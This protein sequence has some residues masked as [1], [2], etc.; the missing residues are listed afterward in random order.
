M[1]LA[2]LHKYGIITT[3]PFSKYASPIFAQRKPNGRLRLLVNLRKINNLITEDYVNNNHP[4][5]TL[6][7]AAQHMAGK[8]LFCK[9]DCSQAYHCLQMA[10]YQSIQMLAFNFASRTFAYRRLAQGLSRSLSAFSSFMRE[11]LDRAIKTDQSAQYVDDIG[12]AA[13]DTKQLCT[14]I[15]T[16]FEC[17]RDAGLKLSMSK[18]H[19]GVKRVDFLG[20]TITPDGVAPQADKVKDFLSKLRFPKSKKALQRY[21]VFLNYYRN[22]IPRLSERLS[23]FF[24]LLKETSKF[25]V[26]T[27]LVEDFTNLNKLLE[28]SCQLALK[29]P[30]KNKQLIVMSDASFTAAGYAIMIVDDPNQKLQS[31]RKTYAPIASDSK[32]FNPTQTKMSIYAKEFLSICFA[33]VEFGHLM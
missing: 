22:Y 8:K 21:I 25:Y 23:P 15:R 14:N 11:Y 7:D 18:C 16:V 28:N 4:V 19:F 27:N 6:S 24:K 29:Q 9:L 10:D 26:P 30:L 20:R 1:E 17:I 32:T 13:N 5:S 31:K 33:F 3:L 2:L 12:I